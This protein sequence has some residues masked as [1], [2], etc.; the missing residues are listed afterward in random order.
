MDPADFRLIMGHL[1]TG[2]TVVA[3]VDPR[4]G[5]PC[6]LTANAVASVSLEPQLVLACVDK[7]ADSHDRIRDAKIFSINVLAADQE[8]LSRRFAAWDLT[9]KFEGVPYRT[10]ASGA[11]VL[12][13]VLAWLDCRLVAAHDAG[14][15]TIFVGEAIEGGQRG[16][17][18]PLL[19]Y[20][21]GY[22]RFVP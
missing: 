7:G 1:V 16:Q 3:S 13:G 18:A 2:V 9:D 12:E 19:Y 4:S 10:G 6:G 17:G 5:D 8:R 21:G 22:G 20:R 11:P 14:D 15:H